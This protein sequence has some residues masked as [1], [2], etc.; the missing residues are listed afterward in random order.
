MTGQG[1]KVTYK[2]QT[3]RRIDTKKIKEEEPDLYDK[4][5]KT[6]TTKVLRITEVKQHGE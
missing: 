3:S 2:D 6:T 1:V 5:T 4:Y